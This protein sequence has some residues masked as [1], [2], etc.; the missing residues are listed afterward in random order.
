VDEILKYFTGDL[1]LRLPLA[2]MLSS[3][4]G[5]FLAGKVR[6]AAFV[7]EDTIAG[8][9]CDQVALRGD[10]ADMQLWIAQGNKPLPQRIV[11]TYKQD[12]GAPQFWAQFSDWNLAPR[13]SKALFAFNPPKD[14]KKIPFSPQQVKQTE[15]AVAT[16]EVK[17]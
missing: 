6:E 8:V 17:S 9:V 4:L 13:T 14:S 16:K 1:G 7:E 11:I 15:N 5:K 2:E 3:Q 10:E 12:K